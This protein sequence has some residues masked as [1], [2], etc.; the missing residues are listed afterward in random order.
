M[1]PRCLAPR[2]LAPALELRLLFIPHLSSFSRKTRAW[3]RSVRPITW[4]RLTARGIACHHP[5]H[6]MTDDDKLPCDT[7]DLGQR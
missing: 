3:R 6:M 4:F 7:S 1:R 2:Q 5:V